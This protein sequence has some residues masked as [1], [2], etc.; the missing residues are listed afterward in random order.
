VDTNSIL[1]EKIMALDSS[2]W[3]RDY[4][5][6]LPAM[7][8]SWYA[9]VLGSSLEYD[10]EVS[11]SM[12]FETCS[13]G[14]L[15][16]SESDAA[17]YLY[18]DSAGGGITKLATSLYSWWSIA[19]LP[20]PVSGSSKAITCASRADQIENLWLINQNGTLEQWWL[21]ATATEGDDSPLAWNRGKVL[22]P[23]FLCAPTN[24]SP[25]KALNIP[26]P[27]PPIPP[28]KR[29]APLLAT[30][31][32]T[33]PPTTASCIS[34]SSAKALTAPYRRLDS[35]QMLTLDHTWPL[36]WARRRLPAL[37][38]MKMLLSMPFSSISRMARL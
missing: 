12:Y 2:G 35:L 36:L 17:G 22:I 38:I 29:G 8:G 23:C 9:G 6:A 26:G 25:K 18:F 30:L 3:T 11:D 27:S 20:D 28:W 7:S 21:N 32:S 4:M 19:D 5:A 31:S 33:R 37:R 10:W 13:W 14:P 34:T 16:Q 1:Q 15:L 24:I